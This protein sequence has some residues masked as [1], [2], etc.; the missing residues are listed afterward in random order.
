MKTVLFIF[1]LFFHVLLI[2]V[3]TR[4]ARYGTGQVSTEKRT[5]A[6][7]TIRPPARMMDLKEFENNH[8]DHPDIER[9]K[10][11]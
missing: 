2:V 5:I 8:P 3:S 1:A 7:K 4:N 9:H 11:T 6:V 10:I